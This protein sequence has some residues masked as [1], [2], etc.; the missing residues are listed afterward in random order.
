MK[1]YLSSIGVP[2]VEELLALLPD[3]NPSVAIIANAWDVYPEERR[4]KEIKNLQTVMQQMGIT[5]TVVD[6]KLTTRNQ[7]KEKLLQNSLVWLMGGNSFYLNQLLHE[8]GLNGF[9]TE[10]INNGLVY[11][12][13]SAGAVL[14][15]KTLHGVELLDDPKEAPKIIWEGLNLIDFSIVP[16]WGMDKYADY[17]KQCRTEMEK[18]SNVKVITNDQA[19]VIVDEK[20]RIVE[21]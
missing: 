1:L 20:V 19:I 12:G 13:E 8:S 18:Y 21:K 15:G 6:L 2:N 17:L 11:G 5:S 16:H 9:I 7:L 4:R 3:S 14:A 10:L